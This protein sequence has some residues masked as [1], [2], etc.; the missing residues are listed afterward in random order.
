M[1]AGGAVSWKSVKQT[2]IASSTMETEFIACYRASNH[3]IWQRNFITELRIVDGIEKPLRIS[4][5]N[6]AT[7]LYSKNN[8]SSSKSKHIDIKFLVVKEKVQSLQVSIEHISTNSMIVDPLTKGL[9]PKVYHE[10]VTHMVIVH[11]NDVIV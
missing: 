6:K 11:I 1:L 4:C 3:G 8:R 5:D 10:H 2:L 9:P 7:E